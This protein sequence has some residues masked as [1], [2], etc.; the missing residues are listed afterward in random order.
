LEHEIDPVAATVI[1]D[2]VATSVHV[3]GRIVG[4]TPKARVA[5]I[6]AGGGV[7]AHMLQVAGLYGAAVV[8]LDVQADKLALVEELGATP[9]ES[10][11]FTELEARSL[12]P[13]G[14]PTAIVDL[15]GSQDS[16]RWAFEAASPGGEIVLLTPFRGRTMVVDPREAVM[17]EIAIRGSRYSTRAE[18]RVAAEL[19][20]TGR[21]RPIIS[22]AADPSSLPELHELLDKGRL[23]GRGALRWPA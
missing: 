7:G 23:V 17:R 6:G 20:A 18:V 11:D 22:E 16:L 21:V 8:G 3:C 10:T 9:V 14:S 2:A 13:A 19:V 15:V 4:L 1:P 5:V 12:W